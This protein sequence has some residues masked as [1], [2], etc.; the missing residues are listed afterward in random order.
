LA[1]HPIYRPPPEF[2]RGN[3]NADAQTDI[4]DAVFL[5]SVLFPGPTGAPAVDCDDACDANDDESLD[6]ADPIAI[7]GALFGTPPSPLA[8]PLTCGPDPS[9]PG[10]PLDCGVFA[11]C[12]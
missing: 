7:L 6:I 4:A 10:G 1:S 11:P 8:P 5:L 3:C 2:V 12:P 9:G